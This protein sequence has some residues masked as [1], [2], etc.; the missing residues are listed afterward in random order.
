[1]NRPFIMAGPNQRENI[2]N[3]PNNQEIPRQPGPNQ[4]QLANP[5]QASSKFFLYFE[6]RTIDFLIFLKT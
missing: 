6:I 3:Q 1:M 2:E 5:R 4:N